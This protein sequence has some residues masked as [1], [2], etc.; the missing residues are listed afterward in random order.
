MEW[1][2]IIA[3][4]AGVAVGWLL[5]LIT[6]FLSHSLMLRIR[7]PKLTR[8]CWAE[9]TPT[10]VIATRQLYAN[11]KVWNL[12]PRM[13]R[14]C[15]GYLLK[16]EEMQGSRTVKT[17][18]ERTMQC[19]WEFDNQR[20]YFDIPRGASPSFNVAM[21]QDGTPGISPRMRLST[22]ELLTPIPNQHI[23]NQHGR[24]RFSG[25][26]TADD[27]EP[28]PYEFEIDWQGT[29]PPSFSSST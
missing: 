20:D 14:Q 19:I 17:V 22:G 2:R 29:W 24:F 27:L 9:E 5:S 7:G 18:F 4:L 21:I 3:A 11:V 10:N 28:V 15:R 13:A 16:I 8:E 6:P 23:F 12:K 25:I 26:V 1:P